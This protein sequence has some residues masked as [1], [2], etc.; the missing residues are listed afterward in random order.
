MLK[1]ATLTFVKTIL[2]FIIGIYLFWLFFS[3]MSDEHIK[4][5]NKALREANYL[6]VIIS[7]ILG[8]IALWSRA[9]RWKYML[10]PIG[11]QTPWKHRYHAMMIGY[12]MNYTIPRAGEP[13]RAAMLYRS[14]EVP[15]AKS[16]GTIIAERAVDV[17]MLGIVF[18]ITLLIGYDDLFAIF[19]EIQ[20]QLGSPR[21]DASG[22]T[23]KEIIY[24]TLAVCCLIG[25]AVFVISKTLRSKI[26]GLIK[27]VLNGVFAIFK[28][29]NPGIFIFH[30]V[31]IWT[32]WILMFA[33][34]FFALEET[35]SV[36][37][38]GMLIGFIVGS[39]GIT[40][41]NGG[42]GIFPLIVGLVVA[43]YIQ[44]SYP[45]DARGIGNALGMIIWLS[46][47]LIM[48]VLGL[49]SLILLPKNYSKDDDKTRQPSQ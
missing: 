45:D 41:T 19:N 46:N 28:T 31:L 6:W 2:P 17:L 20:V 22:F 36:P 38:S 34:P 40:F 12:L 15:F 21:T 7:M 30:T 48:I 24:T 47:T 42:I 3:S 32:C 23:T 25:L 11:Y 8:Y 44:N 16:F 10:E 18:G 43:F 4:S 9:E 33:L 29:K 35:K 37:F 14:D 49:I 27:S 26:V 13:T 1:K 5:F 39:I